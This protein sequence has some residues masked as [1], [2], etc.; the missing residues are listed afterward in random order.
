MN[1]AQTCGMIEVGRYQDA[2]QAA[3]SQGMKEN[4]DFPIVSTSNNLVMSHF[5]RFKF[6]TEDRRKHL[7]ILLA[8][9][10]EQKM[11][12]DELR[13]LTREHALRRIQVSN[14]SA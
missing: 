10:R 5:D 8:Q 6:S 11:A 9:A 12:K 14:H 3:K 4:I 7:M 1:H 13:R 2:V